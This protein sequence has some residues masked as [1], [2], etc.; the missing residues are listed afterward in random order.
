MCLEGVV[1]LGIEEQVKRRV[2]AVLVSRARLLE[3]ANVLLDSWSHLNVRDDFK[4]LE[5]GDD[6]EVR[7]ARHLT[8]D[9]GSIFEEKVRDDIHCVLQGLEV[10]LTVLRRGTEPEEDGV[11]QSRGMLVQRVLAEV[12]STVRTCL[13]PCV[14]GFVALREAILLRDVAHDRVG[15][16]DA[17]TFSVFEHRD[18]MHGVLLHE[19]SRHLFLTHEIHI[20]ELKRDAGILEKDPRPKAIH[21]QRVSVELGL[22]LLCSLCVLVLHHGLVLHHCRVHHG[23]LIHGLLIHDPRARR[24]GT[25]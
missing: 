17:E 6:G 1:L 24:V 4:E 10:C 23:L 3:S 14:H 21:R 13:P 9:E 7:D 5:D 12:Q 25:R 15:L 8:V 19:L 16:P 18:R 22:R 20:H 11:R 2:A